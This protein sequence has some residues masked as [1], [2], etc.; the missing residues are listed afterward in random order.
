MLQSTVGLGL[1]RNRAL[2]FG[3]KL[4]L[5][6]I[7]TGELGFKAIDCLD[8]GDADR[9]QSLQRPDPQRKLDECPR[10]FLLSDC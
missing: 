4:F 2:P 10:G 9:L 5:L 8:G 3:T 6:G 1:L 7:D